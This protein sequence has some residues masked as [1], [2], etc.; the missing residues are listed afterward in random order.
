VGNRPHRPQTTVWR[1]VKRKAEAPE[2]KRPWQLHTGVGW[3]RFPHLGRPM[4]LR[5][6]GGRGLEPAERAHGGGF[7]VPVIRRGLGG[8][9]EGSE[10]RERLRAGTARSCAE[11]LTSW[12]IFGIVFRDRLVERLDER[13][14]SG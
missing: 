11:A 2:G 14:E 6:E 7:T 13:F 1:S 5:D 9:E 12:S 8:Q 10:R 4:R 3:C